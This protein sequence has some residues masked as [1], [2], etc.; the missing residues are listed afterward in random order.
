MTRTERSFTLALA[1]YL[2]AVCLTPRTRLMRWLVCAAFVLCACAMAAAGD[3]PDAKKTPGAT[4]PALTQKV[5]CRKGWSTKSVR[6]VPASLK[7]KAYRAYGLKG[8][9]TGYC[10]GRQGCEIDHLIS[11]E[12]GGANNLKNLWP[13]S[14]DSKPWNAHVKDKLENKLHALVCAGTITLENAQTAIRTDWI[15][16]YTKY[17]GEPRQ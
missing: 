5:I 1:L 3:L 2:L 10:K 14:F 16:A 4:N 13:Q 17:L 6:N 12:I 7:K 11:L 15:A 9:H 8:N